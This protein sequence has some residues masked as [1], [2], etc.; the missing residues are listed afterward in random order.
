MLLFFGSNTTLYIITEY[1][2]KME[3]VIVISYFLANISL[4]SGIQ[5]MFQFYYYL[6]NKSSY[7]NELFGVIT[8]LIC[9]AF[10][11]I[12]NIIMNIENK[13][14][15]AISWMTWGIFQIIMIIYCVKLCK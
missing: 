1:N 11:L 3:Y 5:M 6:I 7:F 15:V 14:I 13:N 9:D 12:I 8:Y 2:I 4:F 10:W